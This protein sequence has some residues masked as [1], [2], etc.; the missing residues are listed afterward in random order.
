MV[1]F[2]F[3][4]GGGG[5]DNFPEQDLL[6]ASGHKNFFQFA[7]CMYMQI[8]FFC[9]MYIIMFLLV[10]S[11]CTTVLALFLVLELFLVKF[12]YSPFPPHQK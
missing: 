10:D 8:C 12:A 9:Y 11:L 2:I 7:T 5:L 4:M 6:S 1:N 3:E